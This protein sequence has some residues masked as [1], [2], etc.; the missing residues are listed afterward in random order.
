MYFTQTYTLNSGY[1][2]PAVGLGGYGLQGKEGEAAILAALDS[3]GYKH[4]DTAEIYDTEVEFGNAMSASKVPREEL[5]VTTKVWNS[6]RTHDRV[7]KACKESLKRLKL[8]YVDLYLIHWSTTFEQG[9]ERIPRDENGMVRLSDP[10]VPIEETWKAMES[11]VEAGLVRSI[12]VSNFSIPKLE[13]LLSYAKIKPAVN[14]IQ[15]HPLF[16]QNELVTWCQQHDILPVAY[17]PLGKPGLTSDPAI[18]KIADELNISPSNVLINWA[19]QR[20]TC[21]IPRSIKPERLRVNFEYHHLPDDVMKRINA[22]DSG[23]KKQDNP[24]DWAIDPFVD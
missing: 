14:Q 12:G 9:D 5:F 10:Q 17:S 16:P 1:K 24:R 3:I 6:N 2:M 21:P 20:G 18:M 22:M 13:K 11:L 23:R 4:V 19:V 8:D 15:A 7:I